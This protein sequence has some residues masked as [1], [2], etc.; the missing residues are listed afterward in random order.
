MRCPG[1]TGSI[2]APETFPSTRYSSFSSFFL[3]SSS[4]SI[5][6]SFRSNPNFLKKL[7]KESK[8]LFIILRS[9]SQKTLNLFNWN[10]LQMNQQ[11]SRKSS[12]SMPLIQELIKGMRALYFSKKFSK[13]KFIASESVSK[14]FWYC[15]SASANSIKIIC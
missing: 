15:S 2:N 14:Q 5:S 13:G 6:S 11:R 10:L 3:F 12:F 9:P 4:I 7:C 8:T 1:F